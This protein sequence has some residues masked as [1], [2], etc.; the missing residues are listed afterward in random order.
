MTESMLQESISNCVRPPPR[1]PPQ[2]AG[3]PLSS[4]IPLACFLLPPF[5][6]CE[7][8]VVGVQEEVDDTE[9]VSSR[10]KRCQRRGGCRSSGGGGGGGC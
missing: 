10:R 9:V 1:P 6:P 8:Q 5:R 7:E 3:P 2:L 4:L